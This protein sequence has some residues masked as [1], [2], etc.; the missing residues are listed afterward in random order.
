MTAANAAERAPNRGEASGA[1]QA[2]P[3]R[4]DGRVV[5]GAR[6]GLIQIESANRFSSASL[7]HRNVIWFRMARINGEIGGLGLI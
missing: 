4:E 6:P 3:T 2:H 7:T 1:L 5:P